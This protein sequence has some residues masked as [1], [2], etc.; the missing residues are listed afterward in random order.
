MDAPF[1]LPCPL[2]LTH[3][4]THPPAR[5]PP[6]QRFLLSELVFLGRMTTLT[7]RWTRRTTRAPL[8]SGEQARPLALAGAATAWALHTCPCPC[9]RLL[10]P[11]SPPDKPTCL[12]RSHSA[13]PPPCFPACSS[14][15]AAC[16]LPFPA[17]ASA[18]S[19]RRGL[20]CAI[21][22]LPPAPLRPPAASPGFLCRSVYPFPA[23][24][25]VTYNPAPALRPPCVPPQPARPATVPRI[26]SPPLLYQL[27]SFCLASRPFCNT[28]P[29]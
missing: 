5:P 29:R 18:P 28:Q 16:P 10:A 20:S 21:L 22:A 4:L 15:L 7:T 6:T 17:P 8:T 1:R 26:R 27:L 12:P 9:P 2:D 14:P 25:G 3:S 11:A 23:S 24:L 13:T 19:G